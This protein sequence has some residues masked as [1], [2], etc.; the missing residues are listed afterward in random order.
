MKNTKNLI[1]LISFLLMSVYLEANS[2]SD[3]FAQQAVWIQNENERIQLSREH[4]EIF[5]FRNGSNEVLNSKQIVPPVCD[6]IAEF[7]MIQG[8]GSECCF[9]INIFGTTPIHSFYV[10]VVHS[11]TWSHPSVPNWTSSLTPGGTTDRY[12]WTYDLGSF[13]G[14]SVGEYLGTFCFNLGVANNQA[15]SYGFSSTAG[16]PWFCEATAPPLTPCGP[17]PTCD[18]TATFTAYTSPNLDCC[19]KVG[20]DGTFPINSFYVD[21]PH[22][23]TYGNPPLVNGWTSSFIPGTPTDRFLW[24]YNSGTTNGIVDL[25]TICFDNAALNSQPVSYGFSNTGSAPWICENSATLASCGL[26]PCNNNIIFTQ[27]PSPVTGCCFMMTVNADVN[28]P[29]TSFYVDVPVSS[30]CTPVA[31]GGGW[32]VNFIDYVTPTE[33]RFLYTKSSGS[34]TSPADIGVFCCDNLQNGAQISYGFTNGTSLYCLGSYSIPPCVGL[35]RCKDSIKATPTSICN[36]QGT[37]LVSIDYTGNGTIEWYKA[38]QDPGTDHAPAFPWTS[39]GT[40][41]SMNTGNLLCN[42]LTEVTTYWYQAI[43][44]DPNCTNSPIVTNVATVTVNPVFALTI[45]GPTILCN[46]GSTNLTLDGLGNNFSCTILWK[47]LQTNTPINPIANTQ[48]RQISLQG[49]TASF[50]DCPF[51]MYHY[52]VTVCDGLCNPTIPF[53]I[54]V[55][56]NSKA[57]TIKADKD[58]ICWGE[59]TKLHIVDDNYCG[60]IQWQINSISGTGGLWVD[61]A[62]AINTLHWNTDR[63]IEDTKYRVKF[64]NGICPEVYS[65]EITVHVQK[66]VTAAIYYH[67]TGLGICHGLLC[68]IVK[69]D[70][71]INPPTSTWQW[72][73]NGSPVGGTN[74]L[75]TFATDLPGNYTVVV[76]D[77]VCGN[78]T[79][80]VLKVVPLT[81][82]LSGPSCVCFTPTSVVDLT[83]TTNCATLAP[84]MVKLLKNGNSVYSGI[85]IPDIDGKIILPNISVN[86]G[87]KFEVMI[88]GQSCNEITTNL[89]KPEGCDCPH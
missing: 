50:S 2:S 30:H 47:D 12:L 19:F 34:L 62:G 69:F 70:L 28:S 80:N 60:D 5:N 53:D 36:N 72:Y 52:S 17:F 41:S 10:D 81:A 85:Q 55:F 58:H 67:G 61:I 7:T 6:N 86:P 39:I 45:I 63:L 8:T 33:D 42:P 51:K 31:P 46:Q 35:T 78:V 18:N 13:T 49:L 54:K 57:T 71:I 26:T 37:T 75:L 32:N 82:L 1:L 84:F 16:A 40:G 11:S 77:P 83:I 20:I 27:V 88:Q 3:N 38:T 24:T 56:S 73:H 64:T 21:V 89:Y 43:L 87:D 23:S 65:P 48:E 15:V 29:V 25:G 59:D 74:Q 4:N 79:S 76:T 9:N 44:T 14:G 68:P 22:L 66:K